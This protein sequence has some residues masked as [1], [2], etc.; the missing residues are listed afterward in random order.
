MRY[1]YQKSPEPSSWTLFWRILQVGSG[2]YLSEFYAGVGCSI[3][4][5]FLVGILSLDLLI[6][7]TGSH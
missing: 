7:Y 2:G 4:C 5:G 3:F 6:P 1:C